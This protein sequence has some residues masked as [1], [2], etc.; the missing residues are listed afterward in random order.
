MR[1]GRAPTL[2]YDIEL[3]VVKDVYSVNKYCIM[4]TSRTT[5]LH[6][7]LKVS[8]RTTTTAEMELR[9]SHGGS[10]GIRHNHFRDTSKL[11]FSFSIHLIMLQQG[12]IWYQTDRNK[13]LYNNR[14]LNL[15]CV[16]SLLNKSPKYHF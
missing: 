9:T 16:S 6:T 10:G 3:G 11:T 14:T 2:L 8:L 12:H 13:S 15:Q 5:C 7:Q 4:I 1:G